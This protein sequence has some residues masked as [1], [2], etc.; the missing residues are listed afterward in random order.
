VHVVPQDLWTGS[1]AGPPLDGRELPSILRAGLR[2]AY[3][4]V[5]SEGIPQDLACY[6]ARL[7]IE[8][9]KA[10]V[11]EPGSVSISTPRP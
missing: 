5:L 6:L 7:E 1:T 11:C 8:A 4:S 3:A 2:D 9:P 10:Q